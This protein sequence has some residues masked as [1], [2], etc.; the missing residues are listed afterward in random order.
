MIKHWIVTGDTHGLSGV[1]KRIEMIFS[2]SLINPKESAL[3][4]LGDAGFNFWLTN[5]ERNR[6]KDLGKY[7]LYIYCVRG[8]HEE[9]PENLGYNL[10]YDENVCGEVYLDADCEYIRYFQDGGEYIIDGYDV[11]TIG[12]A[13][14]VDKNYRIAAAGGVEGSGWFPGEQL[15]ESEKVAIE[16]KVQDKYYD[17]VLTHTCPI[18]WEP[19]DLFLPFIDQDSV[20][21][22]TEK[23]LSKISQNIRWVIWCF[24]HY[25][26]SRA[27][28]PCV[29]QF[30][31][32]FATLH[33]IFECWTGDDKQWQYLHK[34]PNFWG[35][36][37]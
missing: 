37:N 36:E 2:K 33:D 31:G 30:Y 9:R 22:T 4:I 3:I 35:E 6:K 18:Q 8:N 28:S 15:T 24:G 5:N 23:W 34:S 29:Q 16:E 10:I 1:Y 26:A 12:G 21:K 25:H 19:R 27:E 13:Y 32:D 7:G 17:F 11:L 14:S 20:D